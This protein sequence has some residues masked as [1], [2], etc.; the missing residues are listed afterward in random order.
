M[1]LRVSS[2]AYIEEAYNLTV[3]VPLASL[4]CCFG[5]VVGTVPDEASVRASEHPW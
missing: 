2:L 1:R 4:N 3:C 5:G